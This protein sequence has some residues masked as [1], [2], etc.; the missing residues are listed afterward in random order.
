RRRGHGGGDGPGG[1]RRGGRGAAGGRAALGRVHR[2]AF[3]VAGPRWLGPIMIG[4]AVLY[5]VLVV[6]LPFVLALYYSLTNITAG[7]RSLEFV[8][9]RNFAAVVG[10]PKFRTALANTFVFAVGSQ[11]LVIVGASALALALLR[12]FPR[13]R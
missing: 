5:I 3:L 7:S 10:T 4:P 11:V 9:L 2:L 13:K 6:G 8:G 12:D 1:L